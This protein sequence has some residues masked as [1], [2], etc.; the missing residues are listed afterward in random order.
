MEIGAPAVTGVLNFKMGP[1]K[2]LRVDET[3]GRT[4]GVANVPVVATNAALK[5]RDRDSKTPVSPLL[6]M[7]D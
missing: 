2:T 5:E 7:S 6:R 3:V 1:P 4:I